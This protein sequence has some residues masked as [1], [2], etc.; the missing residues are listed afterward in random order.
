MGRTALFLVLGLGIA[1]SYAG[2]QIYQSGEI[3]TEAQ[4][5]YLKYM[6]ARNLARVAVHAALRTYDRN[7]TPATGVDTRFN[8]GTFRLDSLW[9]SAN[10]DT[11]RLVTRGAYADS[12]YVMRVKL[13]RTTRPFPTVKGAI[14]VRATPV[15]LTLSGHASVDG[16][17]YDSTGTNLV[18]SGDLPGITTMTTVDS[19]SVATAGGSNISGNP[20]VK[21]DT[22][23]VDP[24]TFLDIYKN[25]ADYVYNTTGTY[26]GQTWG[27]V[28]NPVI[29]YCNAGDD[30]SFAI[31]FSGGCTGYGI[32][33]VRGNVQFTGN[34][35]FFGLVV[36][37]GFNTTVDFG[38]SGTPAIVGG[39]IVAGNAGASVALKGTGSNAK[40]VYSSSA[41][42]SARNIGK[43]R[44]YTILDWFE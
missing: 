20:A 21:V 36:V 27:S 8:G 3:A 31:K 32:L 12:S 4:Y 33:V 22:S 18:G 13:Y 9:S 11:L 42:N 14:S 23:T 1:M 37:D 34:L 29:V 28:S 5:A 39:I 15:L 16:H 17:N 26:S 7:Q 44:Y 24:L 6:N 40:A 38:A 19:L 43:L 2:L 25:N 10:L 35:S 41:L 30:T